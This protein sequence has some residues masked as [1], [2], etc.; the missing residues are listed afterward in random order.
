MMVLSEEPAGQKQNGMLGR[1]AL[2]AEQINAKKPLGQ[3]G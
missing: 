1:G 2:M 3:R